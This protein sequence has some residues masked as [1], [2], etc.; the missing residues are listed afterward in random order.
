MTH[1]PHLNTILRWAGNSKH[2]ILAILKSILLHNWSFHIVRIL[3][4]CP[5]NFTYIANKGCYGQYFNGWTHTEALAVCESIDAQL[6]S[7]ET[8]QEFEAVTWWYITSE[9]VRYSVV[10]NFYRIQYIIPKICTQ[11]ALPCVN[12]AKYLLIYCY[13]SRLIH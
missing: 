2:A 9:F 10:R 11:F 3:D 1:T 5:H 13:S 12:V 8:T 6:L 7:L 4:P